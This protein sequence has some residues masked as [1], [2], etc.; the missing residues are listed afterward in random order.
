MGRS[1]AAVSA[2]FSLQDTRGGSNYRSAGQHSRLVKA[3]EM[4]P[5]LSL[6]EKCATSV[7]LAYTHTS[8]HVICDS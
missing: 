2:S 7:T 1:V 8:V 3:N 4:A 6:R 5:C